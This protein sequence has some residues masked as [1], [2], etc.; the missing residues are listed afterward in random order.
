M[1]TPIEIE[2]VS[3][4][5]W[6]VQVDSLYEE[7]RAPEPAAAA[8]GQ[9]PANRHNG[10]YPKEC[11]NCCAAQ[12]PP[13]HYVCDKCLAFGMCRTCCER[14]PFVLKWHPK[15][16]DCLATKRSRL[17]KVGQLVRAGTRID[18]AHRDHPATADRKSVV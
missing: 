18:L 4:S 12:A 10:A 9:S 11:G 3:E 16:A 13:M 15:Q 14:Y 8:P 5:Q 6:C 2:T 17:R 7:T 1:K